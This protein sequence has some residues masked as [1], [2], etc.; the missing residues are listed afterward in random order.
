MKKITQSTIV[1][2][3]FLFLY[4]CAKDSTT[5]ASTTD[6]TTSVI[7]AG[8]WTITS[9]TQK[10]EDKTNSFGGVAFTFSSDGKLTASGTNSAT[11]TW[12]VTP[13]STGYY[14]SSS[15]LATFTINLGTNSP[16]NKLTK[17]WNIAEQTSTTLRL[18]NKE[19]TE[20]EH[21][22]FSKK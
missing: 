3:M 12:V 22:T 19:P 21:I 15:S 9:Y 5:P 17:A 14:G 16:F 8:T 18:D 10:T 13:A 20:D 4:S 11:G 2:A 6:S 7:S 1:L